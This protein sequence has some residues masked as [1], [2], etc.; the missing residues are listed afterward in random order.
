VTICANLFPG[1]VTSDHVIIHTS[2]STNSICRTPLE[3]RKGS[4][5]L[6]LVTLNSYLTSGHDGVRGVKILVCV[7]SIGQKK[8][9]NKK[10]GGECDLIDILL[11]D[12]TAELRMTLWNDIIESTKDWQAGKTILLITNPGYRVGFSGKG[13][14]GVQ[15]GT[16]IEVDPEFPDAHWLRKQAVGMTKRESLCLEFPE[17]IW[18]LEAAEYGVQIMLFTFAS[19]DPWYVTRLDSARVLRWLLIRKQGEE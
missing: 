5:L 4:Q 6:G 1:R 2:G 16:M 9:I 13:N 12:H 8:H 15:Y 18:D 11:F 14:I 19:L 17:D 7:K 10:G 3:Y